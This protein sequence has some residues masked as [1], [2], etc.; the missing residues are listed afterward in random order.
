MSIPIKYNYYFIIPAVQPFYGCL[1]SFLNGKKFQIHRAVL[2]QDKLTLVVS[3]YFN[4]QDLIDFINN[5]LPEDFLK[6]HGTM[7]FKDRIKRIPRPYTP[8]RKKEDSIGELGNENK[9]VT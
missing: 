5:E 8:R 6:R 4:P 2:D 9:L 7:R 3:V 1:W